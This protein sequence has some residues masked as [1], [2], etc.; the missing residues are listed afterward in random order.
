M[1]ALIEG[2]DAQLDDEELAR[3]QALIRKARRQES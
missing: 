2:S 1:A 3:M